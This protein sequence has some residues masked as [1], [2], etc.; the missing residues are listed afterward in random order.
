MSAQDWIRNT[1]G[2]WYVLAQGVLV[3][4]VLLAPTLDG[5]SPSLTTAT[6]VVGSILCVI[7]LVLA[8]FGARSLGQSV[9]PF[10]RPKDDT[11][12]VQTGVYAIVRHPIYTGLTLFALGYSL[13]WTSV[14]ALVATAALF[15]ELDMKSRREERWLKE[16]FD[17]YGGYQARVRR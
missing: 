1:R 13:I 15:V 8:A 11:H 10:P 14:A 6:T 3:L 4:F 5:T 9:S 12:L 17:G 16:K 2:E 7:G